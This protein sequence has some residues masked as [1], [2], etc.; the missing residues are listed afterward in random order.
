M[1]GNGD[2]MSLSLELSRARLRYP[3]SSGW[4]LGTRER[5]IGGSGEEA[6]D[7][8]VEAGTHGEQSWSSRG[9]YLS[10]H[11]CVTPEWGPRHIGCV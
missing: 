2:A 4:I 7:R 5:R 1:I 11:V 10:R 9:R 3:S 8:S 6:A